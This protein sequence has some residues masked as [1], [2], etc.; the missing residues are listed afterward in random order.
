MS[1]DFQAAA[2]SYFGLPEGTVL[3]PS[4]PGMIAFHVELRQAVLAGIAARMVELGQ[5]QADEAVAAPF[6]PDLPLSE[7]RAEYNR[8]HPTERAEWGSFG[9]YAVLRRAQAP[10]N[11]P[12]IPMPRSSRNKTHVD[13]PTLG[14]DDLDAAIGAL[15]WPRDEPPPEPAPHP[16]R[17]EWDSMMPHQRL[18]FGSFEAYCA[19]QEQVEQVDEQPLD[20]KWIAAADLTDEQIRGAMGEHAGKYAIQVDNLT[21]AQRAACGWIGQEPT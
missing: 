21:D 18:H 10:R 16:L 8:M 4:D 11:I 14:D 3:I 15:P 9:R 7:L 20:V 17:A 2:V 1:A 13:L 12:D 5:A 19:L 6:V